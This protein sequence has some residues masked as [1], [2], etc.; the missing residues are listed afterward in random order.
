[1]SSQGSF[2]QSHDALPVQPRMPQKQ[3]ST[4]LGS[5]TSNKEELG[6]LP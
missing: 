1:M 4:H 5:V 3:L 6:H 2:L